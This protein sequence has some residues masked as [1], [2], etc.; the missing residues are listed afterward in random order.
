MWSTGSLLALIF[1]AGIF[2][3]LRPFFFRTAGHPLFPL[4]LAP[5]LCFLTYEA[6]R[7]PFAASPYDASQDVCRCAGLALSFWIWADFT[8]GHHSRWR[9]LLSILLLSVT[10][11]SLY[12]LIQQQ[13]GSNLVLMI[14][15]PDVYGM[16][17]SGAFICPNHFASFIGMM[18]P[19][20]LALLLCR[21]SG[22]VL[23]L[24]A[25]YAL[26]VI[27]P[28]LYL[29]QSRSGWMGTLIGLVV[30]SILLAAR[31]RWRSFWIMSIIAPLAAAGIA[32]SA[33]SFSPM[34]RARVE[35]ALQGNNPRIQLWKDT[36]QLIKAS[37]LLGYG[38]ASF[39]LVYPRYWHELKMFTDPEHAHNEFLE[40]AADYG[41]VGTSLLAAG[42]LV[43]CGTL[44]LRLRAATRDKDAALIAG[45]LGA[46]AAVLVHGLFDFNLHVFGVASA[47]TMLLGIAISGLFS[48][49]AIARREWC[50]TKLRRTAALVCALACLAPAVTITRAV[51][52]YLLTFR[53]DVARIQLQ[54]DVA[55][56][57]YER[58]IAADPGNPEAYLGY[59]HLLRTQA[60]LC[61][62]PEQK[63]DELT[64][65][66][67]MYRAAQARSPEKLEI[68]VSL[69]LLY[70]V[71]GDRDRALETFRAVVARAP[72]HRD[73]VVRLGLQLRQMGRNAEALEAFRCAEKL[74]MTDAILI[75][76]RQLEAAAA[77]Q[78]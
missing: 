30:T 64:G 7:I 63:K 14:P 22:Y 25:G 24:F 54:Y 19:L 60:T 11:M 75:N 39:H 65:A 68:A 17:A 78:K 3:G 43:I 61:F 76:L 2:F 37:P 70:N 26:V 4:A 49:G 10:V 13:R 40:A 34:V 74:G 27:P 8:G 44:L 28:A 29:T 35:D 50:G 45:S 18:I 12:A 47:I 57:N 67:K 77:V 1:I 9:W 51:A 15:R 55:R 5:L 48:S 52:S 41:A 62:D 20:S 32:I 73:N 16:R 36:A 6:V 56:T 66:E 59:G 23:R 33:W 46:L 38:P 21:D 69:A 58:A 42:I 71:A 72:L 53:A 31:K